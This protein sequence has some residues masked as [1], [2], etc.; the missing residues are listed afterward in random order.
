MTMLLDRRRVRGAYFNLPT[1]QRK[2]N[3]PTAGVIEFA[4]GF[5]TKWDCHLCSQGV[6]TDGEP[7]T[8]CGLPPEDL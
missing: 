8:V 3:L 1:S 5:G 7:C 4:N 6:M 2:H